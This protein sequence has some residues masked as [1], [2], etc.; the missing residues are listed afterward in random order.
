MTKPTRPCCL[1]I[2]IDFL[3]EGGK[4]R[5][6]LSE[7]AQTVGLHANLRAIGD[8]VRKTEIPVRDATTAFSHEAMPAAHDLN[9]LSFT[10]AVLTRTEL[11]SDLR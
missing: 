9:A 8:A 1:S 10:R 5:P 6:W 4:L 2:H 3:A 7:V 11:L